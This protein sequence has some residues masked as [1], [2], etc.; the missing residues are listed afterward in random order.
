MRIA[1]ALLLACLAAGCRPARS[2][3]GGGGMPPVPDSIAL[4]R[5]L[6]FGLCP[7]YRISVTAAG[8]VHFRSLNPG[9]SARVATGRTD[10]GGFQSLADQAERIGFDRL[11]DSIEDSR[12]CQQRSTDHPTATVTLHRGAAAK[13]VVDYLG[14][15]DGPEELRRR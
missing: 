11:P 5:T 6:C 3:S 9:D 10:P 7:A 15:A 14:C 2:G 8:A 13:R 1:L 12:F 4:E